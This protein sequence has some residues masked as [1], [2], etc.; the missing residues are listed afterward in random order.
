[1]KLEFSIEKLESYVLNNP[2]TE[3]EEIY[4]EIQRDFMKLNDDFV[5]IKEEKETIEKDLDECKNIL[6]NDPKYREKLLSTVRNI[7]FS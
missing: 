5:K 1:M 2:G 6:W 4:L 7:V 3:L